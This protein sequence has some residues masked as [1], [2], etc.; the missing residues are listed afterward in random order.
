MTTAALPAATR[1]G[2]PRTL[3]H[4]SFSSISLF[5][6]CPLRFYFRYLL[7]LPEETTASN[8]VFGTSM[9]AGLEFYFQQMLVGSQAPTLDTLLD[10]FQDAWRSHDGPPIRMARGED[11]NSIGRLAERM[12]RAFL[13]SV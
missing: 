6:Q 4:L 8:L 1:N 2:Q 5:Q 12:F 7:G 3:Q 11:V 13:H 10:V 9:H